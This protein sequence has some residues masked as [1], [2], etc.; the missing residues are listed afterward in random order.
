MNFVSRKA[1]EQ[2]AAALQHI[3]SWVYGGRA[4]EGEPGQL[5]PYE[6]ALITEVD[7]VPAAAAKI[8]D[9]PTARGNADLACGG[10][11]GV[12]TL[13]EHRGTGAAGHLMQFALRE[14]RERGYDISSLYGFRDSYYRKLGYEVCGWRWQINCPQ[15]RLPR[16]KDVLGWKHI[17]P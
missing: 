16:T 11:G 12:A 6:S 17:G 4:P 10:I 2:D 5:L 8:L 15:A 7:G 3:W 13:V 9:L 1:T 14:M